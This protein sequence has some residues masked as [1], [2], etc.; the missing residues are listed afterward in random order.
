MPERID[1]DP[2]ALKCPHSEERQ[3]PGFREHHLVHGLVAFRRQNGVSHGPL[4]GN[5][6][7]CREDTL[8]PRFD[9]GASKKRRRQPGEL[10]TR[11]DEHVDGARGAALILRVPGDDVDTKQAHHS[12]MR[13]E[14]R[15]VQGAPPNGT[16]TLISQR[17]ESFAPLR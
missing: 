6:R 14:S 2:E 16:T 9:A 3:I 4:N 17:F 1:D 13:R 11:V 15:T 12:S 8:T 7:C 5:T 10:G